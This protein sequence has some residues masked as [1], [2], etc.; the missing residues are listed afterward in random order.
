MP[1][2]LVF[3]ASILLL[4]ALSLARQWGVA[5]APASRPLA[6]TALGASPRSVSVSIAAPVSHLPAPH[7]LN[8][9][10][11]SQNRPIPA[12]PPASQSPVELPPINFDP[13][14]DFPV[15]GLGFDAVHFVATHPQAKQVREFKSTPFFPFFGG[16]YYASYP[17]EDETSAQR[18]IR[19]V[20]DVP[21]EE[22]QA[23]QRPRPIEAAPLSNPFPEPNEEPLHDS[24]EYVFVRRDGSVFFA[25]AFTW[26]QRTL[27]YIT[28]QGLRQFLASE[29]LDLEATRQ[30]NEQRGLTFHKPAQ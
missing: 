4:P 22:R 11:A 25:V 23:V 15:P 29:V 24:N 12:A 6:S 20:E 18:D 3:I 10:V 21:D 28:R 16:G 30:F 26:D 19:Q 7:H 1:R 13:G 9:S 17:V 5:P 8:R 27:R 2:R 14:P